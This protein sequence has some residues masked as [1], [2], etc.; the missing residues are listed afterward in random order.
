MSKKEGGGKKK[1][2]HS[3]TRVGSQSESD[4]KL[5][6]KM[7]FHDLDAWVLNLQLSLL[8]PLTN[9]TIKTEHL[10]VIYMK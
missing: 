4:A 3:R 1:D 8:R 5:I 9:G 2:V 6:R 10:Y 7:F